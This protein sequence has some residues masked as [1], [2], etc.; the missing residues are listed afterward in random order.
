MP[1][2]RVPS[3][4]PWR[5]AA[6]TVV[7]ASFAAF[8]PLFAPLL[9][10]RDSVKAPQ[11]SQTVG[12]IL[13]VFD[14]QSNAP[15]GNVEVVDV[16]ASR[17]FRTEASGLIGLAGFRRQHDSAVVRVRKLGYRDTTMLV[18]LG[19]ADTV[20][21]QLFI[22]R[23]TTLPRVITEA[24]ETKHRIGGMAEFDERFNDQSLRGK[25]LTPA[26]LRKNDTRT[27]ADLLRSLGYPAAHCFQARIFLDGRR[28]VTPTRTGN[29]GSH[30]LD[31]T[32]QHYE[33]VE[34]Y[35]GAAAPIEYGRCSIL[36]W[37]RQH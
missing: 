11:P 12:R 8:A 26:E 20:P 30:D 36:L 27:L 35:P 32:A 23:V 16:L 24:L 37:S 7:A 18:M 28:V 10:Q 21:M 2:S 34:F 1:T 31:D 17:T 3:R 19:A 4:K 22:H 6:V 29:L 5:L 15:I 25:F 33:A 14:D 13:G 9:A